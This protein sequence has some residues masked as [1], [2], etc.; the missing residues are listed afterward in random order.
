MDLDADQQIEILPTINHVM[1]QE[2]VRKK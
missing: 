1:N 2:M